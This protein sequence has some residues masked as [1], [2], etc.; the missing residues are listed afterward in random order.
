MA[1][2]MIDTPAQAASPG[3]ASAPV[4]HTVSMEAA[5]ARAASP[6][7]TSR[8]QTSSRLGAGGLSDIS[9]Q[10]KL[11]PM[12]SRDLPQRADSH[13]DGRQWMEDTRCVHD[14]WRHGTAWQSAERRARATPGR[15]DDE[16]QRMPGRAGGSPGRAGSLGRTLSTHN[17]PIS[18]LSP[19]RSSS[20]LRALSPSRTSGIGAERHARWVKS[21]HAGG[22]AS[23]S[24]AHAVGYISPTRTRAESTV[25][26]SAYARRVE[27]Q[28]SSPR[29]SRAGGYVSPLRSG[30]AVSPGRGGRGPASTGASPCCAWCEL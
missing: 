23:P 16:V 25:I 30:R 21:K 11:S 19:Q 14:V 15:G 3:R 20:N 4:L 27:G 28:N 22:Y 8:R 9:Q 24:R 13:P 2:L 29:R 26:T 6:L 10:R 18:L 17:S 12:C 7:R 5:R 1:W